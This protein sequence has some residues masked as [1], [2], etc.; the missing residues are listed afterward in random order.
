MGKSALRKSLACILAVATIGTGYVIPIVPSVLTSGIVASAATTVL[1][2]GDYKYCTYS[3]GVKFLGYADETE[4]ASGKTVTHYPK[5][6]TME[7]PGSIDG[8]IVLA[9]GILDNVDDYMESCTSIVIPSTVK[10]IDNDVFDGWENVK[11]ITFNGNSLTSIGSNAFYGCKA[12]SKLSITTVADSLSIGA[13]AFE[14]CDSLSEVSLSSGGALK[15]AED[16]FLDC[17]G[18]S[19]ITLTSKSSMTIGSECFS[20]CSNISKVTLTSKS[21]LAS[22]ET[23]ILL[24]VKLV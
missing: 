20:G 12:L 13:S 17:S 6:S 14:G 10:V 8:K 15:L 21:P 23:L 7:I 22:V 11:K 1:T 19:K 16:A 5:T 24:Y 4:T 9:I 2:K 3:T 18:I